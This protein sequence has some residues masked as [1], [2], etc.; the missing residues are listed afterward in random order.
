M[1]TTT[2]QARQLLT[3]LREGS[4]ALPSGQRVAYTDGDTLKALQLLYRVTPETSDTGSSHLANDQVRAMLT[5]VQAG[6]PL[7]GVQLGQLHV[8]LAR[9]SSELAAL[10]KSGNRDGQDYSA[11]PDPATGRLIA[12]AAPRDHHGR[13]RGA[14]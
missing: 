5:D 11:V 10:R 13:F 9:Y 14:Q 8:L 6:K 3:R 1:T 7:S 4:Y 12:A 2:T